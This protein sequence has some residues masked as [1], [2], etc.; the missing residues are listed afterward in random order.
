[1]LSSH[2]TNLLFNLFAATATVTAAEERI[3][4]QVIFIG[5]ILYQIF[6]LP[7]PL[8]PFMMVLVNPSPWMTSRLIQRA[9]GSYA[10]LENSK[11]GFH[12]PFKRY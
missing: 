9:S 4:H 3:H 11:I 8:F 10:P 6:S 2:P 7:Y 1:M 5:E 12:Q